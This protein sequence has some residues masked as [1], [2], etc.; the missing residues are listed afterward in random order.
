MKTKLNDVQSQLN[1]CTVDQV[2]T[3]KSL[4]DLQ[5]AVKLADLEDL[6]ISVAGHRH[7][8]GGQQFCDNSLHI[9]LGMFDH[10]IHFDKVNGLVQVESGITWTNLIQYLTSKQGSEKNGWAINQKQTGVDNVTIAGSLSS[11]IHGRGLSLPPFVSDVESFS[12]IGA[13]GNLLTCSRTENIELFSLVIGGYGMFGIIAYV[14]LRLVPRVKVKRVVEVIAVK[15]LLDH[16]EPRI[17]E[18]ALYGDCQ[19]S[20]HIEDGDFPHPGIFSYYVTVSDDTPI[21]DNQILL[22]EDDWGKL[23]QLSRSNKQKAFEAYTQYYLATTGQVYWSDTHQLSNVFAG[24]QA[25]VDTENGTEMITE[26]Y[27]SKEAYVEFMIEM[28]RVCAKYEFD[29]TYGTIRFIKKDTETFLAWAKADY[30]C[31]VCNLHVKHTEEGKERAKDNFRRIIDG[32]IKY[33]GNFY[34]T[35]HRWATKQQITTCYPQFIDFLKLKLKYDPAERFQSNWYRH[36]KV[37]FQEELT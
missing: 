34:L 35:Y 9:D 12:L 19:Y 28:R 8:M 16:I 13:D 7:S 21:E 17:E 22:A 11:N 6:V 29:V 14:T 5:S 24:Y 2:T 33:G 10:V 31:I 3:P 32:V 18:G 30:V 37:M 4:T 1:P 36:Y 25:A 26:V 15:E 20:I 27:V 23:Y